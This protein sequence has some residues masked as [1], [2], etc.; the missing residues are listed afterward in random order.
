VAGAGAAAA[1]GGTWHAGSWRLP[2]HQGLPN[3]LQGDGEGLGTGFL[4]QERQADP[5]NMELSFKTPAV[6][7]NTVVQV[8]EQIP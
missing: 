1:A 5:R 4:I 8:L 2:E 7:E 6:S 3:A